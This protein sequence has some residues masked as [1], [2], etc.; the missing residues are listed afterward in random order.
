MNAKAEGGDRLE[1]VERLCRRTLRRVRELTERIE[2]FLDPPRERGAPRAKRRVRPPPP[3]PPDAVPDL[4]LKASRPE[5]WERGRKARDEGLP[6]GENPF[7][8]TRGGYRN[9]WFG[10]WMERDAELA[11]APPKGKRRRR[12]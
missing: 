12:R 9:A 3:P 7:H 2:W 4:A 5:T 8:D 10:G 1:V 6:K 11:A